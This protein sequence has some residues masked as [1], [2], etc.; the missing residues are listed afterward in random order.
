MLCDGLH[1]AIC[2]SRQYFLAIGSYRLDQLYNYLCVMRRQRTGCV[3]VL[4]QRHVFLTAGIDYL[5]SLGC[6]CYAEHTQSSRAVNMRPRQRC[7]QHSIKDML[8]HNEK[9]YMV[10]VW[11]VSAFVA[12]GW[13]E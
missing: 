3:D 10:I 13:Y 9:V 4:D 2:L 5:L 12:R 7:M 1:L 11:R 8:K 6:V